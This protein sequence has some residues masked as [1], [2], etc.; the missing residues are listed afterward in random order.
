[1]NGTAKIAVF[2][3]PG[4]GKSTL[5]LALSRA[6]GAPLVA[7]DLVQYLPGGGQLTDAEFSARHAEIISQRA[8]VIDG[9]GTAQTF[10]ELLRAADVL[11]YVQRPALLHYWWVTKRL[12]KSPF[13]PPLG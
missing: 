1:M 9:V 10:P 4:G 13:T 8:W 6:T 11:V 2:G 3:P 7:L 12:L 5:C